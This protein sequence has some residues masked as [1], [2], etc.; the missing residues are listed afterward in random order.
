MWS[1]LGNPTPSSVFGLYLLL[2]SPLPPPSLASLN[3]SNVP[4]G[5]IARGSRRFHARIMGGA[6]I[7]ITDFP[8]AVSIKK[9]GEHY[10]GGILVT[11]LFTIDRS[12]PAYSMTIS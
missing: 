7:H 1:F 12:K 10:C 4:C 6:A 2:L 9:N 8:N 5:V 3:M 11:L